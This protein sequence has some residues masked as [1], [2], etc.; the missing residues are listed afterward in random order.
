METDL[1]TEYTSL[2]LNA[3]RN[4]VFLYESVYTS[5]E[6]LL[7]QEAQD[8]VLSEYRKEGLDKISELREPA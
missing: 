5:E 1:A 2:F 8:E 3:G 6:R 4:T 7:M